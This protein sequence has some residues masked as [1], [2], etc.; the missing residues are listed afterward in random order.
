M[1]VFHFFIVG[2]DE[3]KEGLSIPTKGVGTFF[4]YGKGGG[5]GS[6]F[7]SRFQRLWGALAERALP[8][9][10]GALLRPLGARIVAPCPCGAPRGVGDAPL[11]PYPGSYAPDPDRNHKPPY[12]LTS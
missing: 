2:R 7:R 5:G 1:V 6:L 8:P 10:P 11:R 4:G 3:T 9:L 12:S